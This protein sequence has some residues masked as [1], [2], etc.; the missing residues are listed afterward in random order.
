MVIIVLLGGMMPSRSHGQAFPIFNGSVNTCVGAFL[1]SGGEGGSGYGNNENFTYTICPDNPNDAVSLNFLTFQLDNTGPAPADQMTIY[2][3]NSTAAPTLGTY[4]GSSLEGYVV[5]ASPLNTSGC[6]TVVFRS[7]A[8]GTGIFAASI[9][10][11]TPCQRPTAVASMS[12]AAPAMVCPGEVVSFN[13]SGSFAAPG[14]A[15]ANRRWEWGDGS[16]TDPAPVNATHAY[17]QPG[18][19]QA[20]LYLLDDNGCASTNR[21]DLEVLVGTEPTFNGTGGDVLGCVGEV[22]CLDAVVNPVTF[23]ELPTGDLGNG[24]FLADEVGSCFTAEIEFTQFDPGQTLTSIADLFSI[25]M[26]MEH[27]FIGD[28]VVRIISPT[29][30]TVTMHQQGGGGTFLGV[31]VD[32]DAQPNVQGTCWQYCF[33]P[34]AT[35]GTWVDNAGGTLPSGTYESLNNLDGLVGSQLNGIWQLQIC[36]LWASDNGFVCDWNINFDPD[37]FPDLVEFTP[38]YGTDCD[39]SSWSGPNITSTSSTCQG[40]CITPPGTGVFPYTYTVTD[41]FGCTYDTTLSI[42][43]IPPAIIN[44]GPDVSTCDTPVQLSATIV[45]GGFPSPCNY[46]LVL[47]DS[48]GDGWTTG[49]NISVTVNGVSTTYTLANGSTTTFNIPVTN[50][51]TVIL[52]YVAATIWNN[53]QSFILRN[54]AGATVYASPTGPISGNPW[55]GPAMCPTGPFVYSWSP[56]TGLSNPNIANPIATVSATTVYCVTAYQPGHPDCPATDC[57][58]IIVDNAVDPGTNGNVTVCENAAALDLFSQLGGTPE[59]G[60]S[61]TGPSNAPHPATFTPGV[62]P[63]GVYTYTV[64]GSGACGSSSA[65]STVTVVVETVPDAGSNGAITVCSTDGIQDLFGALGGSPQPGGTWTGPG[66]G[67]AIGA[68]DPAS[69]PPGVYTYTV[70]GT[71]PCPDESATVTVTLNVPPSAGVDGSIT[72]CSSDAPASLFDQLGGAPDAGGSWSGP[73]VVSGGMIDPATMSA[74]VYTYTVAGLAPCPDES[75]TVTVTINTPPDPGTDGAIALCATSPPTSLFAVLGGSPDAGGSWAGPSSLNGALFDPTTMNAGTYT[76]TVN[77]VAPC[78]A[79][80]AD[81]MVNV[82]SD[83][84]PGIPGSITLC[85]S[86]GVVDLFDQLGGSPD[87]GGSWTGPSVVPGGLFDPGAMAAGVYTYTITVPPP[88][89]S[90]NSTVTVDLV[91]PPDAGADGVLTLC[92][93][94][95][96]TALLPSLGGSPDTGGTWSGPSAVVGGSFN[97]ASMT[98]GTY[99]Y[100]V[101]GTAPCPASSADVLVNVATTPDAG[102]PGNITVCASDIP[103]DLFDQ[104]GG[105][106]D[107]GGTWSGPSTVVSGQFDPATMNAGVYTY[108]IN[109]PPPCVNVSSTVT[110][111][112]VQPP[113]AGSDG[114]L[115][116]CISSPTTALLPALGGSPD[117]GGTWSGPSAVVGG[118]FNPASMTPGTYTYT[119]AGTAPCPASSADVLVN[120]ATTPDAGTPGNITVCASDI[121]FDLFDQLGGTP[122]IGGTWSGPSTVVS[123]QFDPATMN[124]GVYTYTINVPP[125]CVNVSSTVTVALVQPP[126]AGSDG[127]LTLCISSPTT[128]LL[129]SLGG[130]PDTGGTWSGPS[131]VVGGSFNPASMTAGTYTYTVIGAAPC[132]ASSADVVVDVVDAPNAGLP[133]SSDLCATDEAIALFD[134]LGGTPDAGGSWSGPSSVSSGMFNPATMTAGVYTYTITVPPPCTNASS[135]VTI[136]VAQPPNGG[137]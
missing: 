18:Y 131:A 124:A 21:V 113:H 125:P 37:L 9:S 65:T 116:L 123:G 71:A 50:G 7:N 77:G 24:V 136:N 135:T 6:L 80:S 29:G 43:V 73:S 133:G 49:S 93:S 119:V 109:V 134:Q 132:P 32:N 35:N 91:Q 120:V 16:V 72:L 118:S 4:T 76:Y 112:L 40:I 103:F 110:V 84:D 46:Q 5:N 55:S 79:A 82:V 64:A 100:T 128:A 75:A 96:T 51:A 34:S 10:C 60:G 74:G 42:T 104:L 11:Y 25:C 57:V 41:N 44:A 39:S 26:N 19:Y 36:D 115:T 17:A 130:S 121:P 54:S 61:W 88:C 69:D 56:T 95:P 45:S 101:A 63:G 48:F 66:S 27:S 28:L 87:P 106:P 31:P 86:A 129:P 62:D 33:S 47:N 92:I 8:A 94:S 126:H 122:D 85:T 68:Y 137:S 22:L 108:T 30:Q 99:T 114:S 2:D 89:V 78:P 1:D 107:I 20:Q 81:V 127:S 13:S 14:F 38:V 3:G 117:T 105:T 111:A 15:V 12:E 67:S 52:N 53:E 59:A 102:T 23:N 83:P 97:P 58:T 90:V 98:P 70:A